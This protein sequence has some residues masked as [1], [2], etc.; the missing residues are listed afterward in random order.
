MYEI[1][2]NGPAKRA[3]HKL[4]AKSK[5]V[6]KQSIPQI[7]SDENQGNKLNQNFMPA[8]NLS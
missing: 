3:F 8:L 1:K 7:N 2:P 4:T 5:Q 6:Q